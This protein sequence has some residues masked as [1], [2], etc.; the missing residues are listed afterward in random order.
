MYNCQLRINGMQL[1][2]PS[3]YIHKYKAIAIATYKM[4][5]DLTFTDMIIVCSHH[6]QQ[7]WSFY[8]PIA[9]YAH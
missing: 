2:E 4:C 7:F 8:V 6:E 5:K 3:S 1:C 9:V